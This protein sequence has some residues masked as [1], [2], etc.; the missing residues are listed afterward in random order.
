MRISDWSSDVCSSDLKFLLHGLEA[1][2]R[3]TELL[4]LERIVAR[5]VEGRLGNA[6]R[7]CG[8]PRLQDCRQPPDREIRDSLG[9]GTVE[10]DARQ[11]ARWVKAGY[12]GPGDSAKREVDAPPEPH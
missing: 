6:E 1:T 4:T 12:L 11:P 2:D 10:F 9:A 5:H 7:F 8:N 3:L